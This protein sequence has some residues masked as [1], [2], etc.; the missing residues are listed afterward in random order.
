MEDALKALEGYR[1]PIKKKIDDSYICEV[2]R[3]M[4]K[5]KT[6]YQ[7]MDWVETYLH[8]LEKDYRK[9]DIDVHYKA[10]Q[11]SRLKEITKKYKDD[12]QA[13]YRDIK[14]ARKAGEISR[15]IGNTDSESSYKDIEGTKLHLMTATRAKGHEYDAVIVLD[16]DMEEWPSQL[17][18]DIE[19]E[20][21]LFYV[22]LSRAKKYLCFVYAGDKPASPFLHETGLV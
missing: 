21:R 6:V 12:F 7:F 4:M 16:A 17:A 13:F 11:F 3:K 18:E 9:A 19:E 14:T 1:Q 20:R 5:A 10:P 15:E 2:V 22:A 8:G